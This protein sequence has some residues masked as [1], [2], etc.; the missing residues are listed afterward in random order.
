[1]IFCTKVIMK[2]IHFVPLKIWSATLEL[3]NN[4]YKMENIALL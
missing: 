1:M 2:L 4:I 3:Q